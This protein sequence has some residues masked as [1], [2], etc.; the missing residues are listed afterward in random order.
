MDAEAQT[1]F[2]RYKLLEMDRTIVVAMIYL[3]QDFNFD[4]YNIRVQ[5]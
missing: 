1:S 2:F 3:P 4:C 5:M